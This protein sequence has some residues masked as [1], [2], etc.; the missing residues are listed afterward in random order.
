MRYVITSFF[1]FFLFLYPIS[2]LL[3]AADHVDAVIPQK[4]MGIEIETSIIKIMSPTPEKIGFTIGDEH[5]P[6][7]V[8][9][10]DTLDPTFGKVAGSTEFDRNMELKSNYGKEIAAINQIATEIELVLSTL[11]I[12]SIPQLEINSQLLENVLRPHSVRVFPLDSTCP[13]FFIKSKILSVKKRTIRPQVT[14]QLPLELIPRVFKRLQTLKHLGIMQFLADLTPRDPSEGSKP[15]KASSGRLAEVFKLAA[16]NKEKGKP[17]RNYFKEHVATPYSLLPDSRAKGFL[18]LFLYYWYELFNAK[19][20]A[21][22]EPGLKQYLGVMSRIPLS[23]LYASLTKEEQ[24][25]FYE[26]MR[27]HLIFGDQ[28]LLRPY[29]DYD[30][31]LLNP[32]MTLTHWFL[33]IIEERS[34]DSTTEKQV[35][36]LSPPP[37]LPE[38][39]S[40][41]FLDINS[42]AS[43]LALIEARG[44]SSVNYMGKDP[45]I[46]QIKDFVNTESLW[47]FG[48]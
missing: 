47:F 7:W 20:I 22:S 1:L 39:Y 13:S 26:F 36:L 35:D 15:A 44:Y 32:P 40:M 38:E 28:S 6:S 45:T 43:G 8:L 19:E 17:I 46:Y 30:D 9:E 10:E 2:T 21:G 42:H 18:S 3:K 16:Q 48:N 14:Y 12:Q 5:M 33:S 29:Y 23:Q 11:Y 25:V 31:T 34:T 27:N 41:G 24:G 37:G 4:L